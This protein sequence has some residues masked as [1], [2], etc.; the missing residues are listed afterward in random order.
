LIG[1]TIER[2]GLAGESMH[3]W[4]KMVTGSLWRKAAIQMSDV[5]QDATPF[6]VSG[7]ALMSV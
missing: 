3:P 6:A 2:A 7:F 1:A 5:R 4:A